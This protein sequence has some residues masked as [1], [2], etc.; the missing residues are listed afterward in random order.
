MEKVKNVKLIKTK[1][2]DQKKIAKEREKLSQIIANY[3]KGIFMND[4]DNALKIN[5]L[6]HKE[7]F[8]TDNNIDDKILYK[9]NYGKILESLVQLEFEYGGAEA[10]DIKVNVVCPYNIICDD[11]IFSISSL[12]MNSNK[13]IKKN[14]K[15]RVIE[16]Y[17]PTFLNIE[18]YASY[19]AKEKNDKIIQS[20]SIS[21]ELPLGLI[22]RVENENKTNL[23]YHINL[24][25]DKQI[26]KISDLFDDLDK[27]F[28]DFDIL[29]NKTFSV[30]FSY[31]NKKE[32][33]INVDRSK[34]N[35]LIESDNFE[36]ILFITNQIVSRIKEKYKNNVDCFINDKFKVKDYFFRVRDHY[37]LIQ[38]KK[39]LLKNL[40]KYTSLY[41][42][43]QKNLLNKYQKKTPPKLANLDF[44]LKTVYKDIIHQTDLIEQSQNEIQLIYRD[45]YIWTESIVYLSKLRAKLNEEEYQLLR[46][47]FPLDS[48]SNN[49]SSWEDITYSN[50]MN[51]HLY[52]FEDNN[53]L[54]EINNNIDFDL[55]EKAFRT[56]L[57][58]IFT[59]KGIFKKDGDNA[60]V[61]TAE[62]KNTKN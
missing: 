39:D 7:I 22:I 24:E 27:S 5:A 51:F 42:N 60:S 31:P 40:E 13:C 25:T 56:I 4:K 59:R 11:P 55:W 2:I 35:Y 10:S 41:T 12:G 6:V 52:Y 15:F 19:Y 14:L 21:F 29:K 61:S 57:N 48:I 49:E 28:I 23:K 20:S 34:G 18:V 26:L 54:K 38:K 45:I 47:I 58:D 3:E 46:N 36:C 53:K 32:V 37:D 16:E 62:S 8:L 50:M 44:F 33:A 1:D 43:L 30:L 17:Y 9:D